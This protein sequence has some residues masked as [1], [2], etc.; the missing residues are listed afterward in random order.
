VLSRDD[1]LSD[2]HGVG[3]EKQL[4]MTLESNPVQL[5]L[6]HRIKQQFGPRGLLN[7]RKLLP[8]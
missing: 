6:R 3:L 8:Q 2:E 7:P 4:F 1:S 5:D